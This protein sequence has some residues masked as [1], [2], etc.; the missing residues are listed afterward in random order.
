MSPVHD[1]QQLWELKIATH[2]NRIEKMFFQFIFIWYSIYIF[3]I[4]PYTRIVTGASG[5][6]NARWKSFAV[7]NV[8]IKDA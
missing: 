2:M 4:R 7:R 6:R 3:E 5:K 1:K 8:R